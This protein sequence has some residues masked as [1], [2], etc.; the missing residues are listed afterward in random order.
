MIEVPQIPPHIRTNRFIT[1]SVCYHA[2]LVAND[3]DAKMIA[4]LTN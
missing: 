1:K 3:V 2:A 4:T